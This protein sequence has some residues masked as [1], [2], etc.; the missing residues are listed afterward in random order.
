MQDEIIVY[1]KS[2]ALE[3]QNIKCEDVELLQIRL[4]DANNQYSD[5]QLEMLEILKHFVLNNNIQKIRFEALNE[6]LPKDAFAELCKFYKDIQ[7]KTRCGV[8]VQ[9]SHKDEQKKSSAKKYW[10]IETIVK[11]NSE[12]EKVCNFIKE[13]GF[14]PME[15][16]AYI[17]GYVQKVANYTFSEEEDHSW[18]DNDQFFAGAFMHM[19]EVVCMGYSALMEQIIRTLDM[20]GLECDMISIKFDHKLKHYTASHARCFVRVKDEKYQIEQTFFDDPTWDN[21]SEHH[22]PIFTHFA[23]KNESHQ[24]D[25]SKMYHYY[26]PKLVALEDN[27]STYAVKPFD[28]RHNLKN[29]SKIKMNQMLVEKIY[30]NVL[31]KVYKTA[32]FDTLYDILCDMTKA[33]HQE[34]KDR[35]FDGYIAKEKPVL[36]KKVA[37][38]LFGIA[39]KSCIENQENTF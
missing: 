2:Q 27:N 38:D 3:L 39:E 18:Y 30:F 21:V 29:N 6:K 19:P 24:D 5:E 20:P 36:S 28:E 11:A 14:S 17:H 16:L 35:M 33:S 31:Q 25:I 22:F 9:H 37:R 13:S 7:Y 26:S 10:D 32:D 4:F 1:N 8:I 12:I 34:Q 23:M 15:A